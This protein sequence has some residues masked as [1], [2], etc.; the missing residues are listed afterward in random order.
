MLRF[1]HAAA[2]GAGGMQKDEPRREAAGV[3][4]DFVQVH[5]GM[6]F[7][8]ALIQFLIDRQRRF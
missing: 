7:D 5:T 8:R 4:A 3:R 2:T 1:E 6:T